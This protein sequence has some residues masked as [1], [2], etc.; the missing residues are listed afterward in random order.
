MDV[1][2]ESM[3]KNPPKA[4][5]RSRRKVAQA[6]EVSDSTKEPKRTK[7]KANMRKSSNQLTIDVDKS[8]EEGNEASFLF[9]ATHHRSSQRVEMLKTEVL[10]TR[11]YRDVVAKK[12]SDSEAEVDHDQK[13]KELEAGFEERVNNIG[14]RTIYQ[15][16]S[17][18]PELDFSFWVT[19]LNHACL[20]CRRL[21][22]KILARKKSLKQNKKISPSPL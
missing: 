21:G 2:L 10:Q 17:A 4:D 6:D 1:D 22:R 3:F 16:W 20:L 12:W 11:E 8:L 5:K 14:R 15:I 13:L 7:T 19:R 9:C 18:N